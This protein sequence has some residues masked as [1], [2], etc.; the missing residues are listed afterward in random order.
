MLGALRKI[1]E[2]SPTGFNAGYLTHLYLIRTQDVVYVNSPAPDFDE[3]PLSAV[4]IHPGAVITQFLLRAK[5]AILTESSNES[6]DGTLYSLSLSF[7]MRGSGNDITAWRHQNSHCRYII[8]C[9][10]TLGNCYLAGS[11]D[12]GARVSW[13]RQV[14]SVSAHQLS[15]NLV[16]WHPILLIPSIQLEKIFPDREFDYSFD[17]SFS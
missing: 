17:S 7:P 16:S 11:V 12:N 2:S 9:R 6:A 15:L 13:S 10:D 8:L 14:S 4:G 3:Q 1:G 5:T